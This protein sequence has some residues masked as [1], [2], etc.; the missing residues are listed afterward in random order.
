M[1]V[2]FCVVERK[3]T[4]KNYQQIDGSENNLKKKK[5]FTLNFWKSKKNCKKLRS[6]KSKY[7]FKDQENLNMKLEF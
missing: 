5:K 3:I 4:R 1:F 2:Q 6:E 7:L